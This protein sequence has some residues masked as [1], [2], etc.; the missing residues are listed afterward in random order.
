MTKSFLELDEV[1]DLAEN[2]HGKFFFADDKEETEETEETEEEE[3]NQG[4]RKG[5]KIGV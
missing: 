5:G 3:E 2:L 1:Q 4:D